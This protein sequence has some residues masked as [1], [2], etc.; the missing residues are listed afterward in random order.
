MKSMNVNSVMRVLAML[1]CAGLLAACGGGGAPEAVIDTGGAGSDSTTDSGNNESGSGG[2]EEPSVVKLGVGITLIDGYMEEPVV[3]DRD[4]DGVPDALDEYPDESPR[5]SDSWG[6]SAFHLDRVYSRFPEGDIDAVAGDGVTIVIEGRGLDL[7]IGIPLLVFQTG[8]GDRAV[9]PRRIDNKTWEAVPPRDSHSVFAVIGDRRSNDFGLRYLSPT[10]PRI[11]DP[12]A[13][14]AAGATVTLDG[15][16]LD[17]PLI[18]ARLGG[19]RLD[20]VMRSATTLQ[21]RLPAAPVSNKLVVETDEDRSNEIE[22]DIRR[23]VQLVLNPG[24]SLPS[25]A[26][27]SGYYRKQALVISAQSQPVIDVPAHEAAIV[28]L[29]LHRADGSVEYG[30]LAALAWPDESQAVVSSVN[31]LIAALY[32]VMW[33]LPLAEATEWPEIRA[34]LELALDSVEADAF[35]AGLESW[36]ADGTSF[37]HGEARRQVIERIRQRLAEQST[38]TLL[39]DGSVSTPSKLSTSSL[40][41]FLDGWRAFFTQGSGPPITSFGGYL[42]DPIAFT[43]SN[44]STGKLVNNDNQTTVDNAELVAGNNYSQFEIAKH[45]EHRVIDENGT[46]ADP[47]CKIQDK[48]QTVPD[49]DKKNPPSGIRPSDLC[50]QNSTVMFASFAVYRPNE[51]TFNNNY[52]LKQSDLVRRHITAVDDN[53]ALAE[54]GMFLTANRILPVR[55]PLC[56]MRTC[57]VEVIT[58]GLGLGIDVN[59]TADEENIVKWLRMRSLYE[60]VLKKVVGQ[61]ANLP[62]NQQVPG[63]VADLVYKD[64]RFYEEI[65]KFGVKLRDRKKNNQVTA[66]NVLQDFVD[67]IGGFMESLLTGQS[68]SITTGVAGNDTIFQCL[69]VHVP[70]HDLQKIIQAKFDDV[71]ETTGLNRFKEIL[72]QS[73]LLGGVFLTPEK[74]MFKVGYRAEV[75]DIAF[76]GEVAPEKVVIDTVDGLYQDEARSNPRKLIVQGTWLAN[77]PIDDLDRAWY[78]TLRFT[79]KVGAWVEQQLDAS[80][81][82]PITDLSIRTL[83]LDLPGFASKFDQLRAGPLRTSVRFNQA[84]FTEESKF[85]GYPSDTLSVPAPFTIELRNQPKV[86]AFEPG[87][88]NAGDDITMIGNSLNLYQGDLELTLVAEREGVPDV[89]VPASN[90]RTLAAEEIRFTIPDDVMQDEAYKVLLNTSD[91]RTA[92][93]SS[94]PFIVTS[95]TIPIITF[96]DFGKKK[97]DSLEL[98]LMDQLFNEQGARIPL[99]VD[100]RYVRSISIDNAARQGQGLPPIFNI[101]IECRDPGNDKTCT[102][103]VSATNATLDDLARS[104]NEMYGSDAGKIRKGQANQARYGINY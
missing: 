93:T 54:G 55:T 83:V 57:Y 45:D 69:A 92:T 68:G 61:I 82:S 94:I 15:A 96:A 16:N 43:V 104:G 97:D 9:S 34:A 89:S 18:V 48:D 60:R 46:L 64:T 58:G 98:V 8:L 53:L 3:A 74:F 28:W 44:Y 17:N 77:N 37:G 30:A 38:L 71:V 49:K 100:G 7:G 29:D 35:I 85:P 73:M 99:P 32:Q 47:I 23:S 66:I 6:P 79:D 76:A 81:V 87:G 26:S 84:S 22:L 95:G 65:G 70:E 52:T 40:M 20:I 101:A 59:L 63:C 72:Q 41:G 86:W 27:V 75:T 51:D 91:G 14:V 24:L 103:G 31:T 56:G 36:L 80:N 25:G 12:R 88:A 102:F 19:E 1:L 13:S 67:T 39:A 10:S 2:A 62:S 5:L 21:V 90:V 11:V 78:P 42:D 4:G 33:E 50:V